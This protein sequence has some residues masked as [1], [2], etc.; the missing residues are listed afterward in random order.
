MPEKETLE[1]PEEIMLDQNKMAE[2]FK[3]FSIGGMQSATIIRLLRIL[4]ML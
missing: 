1:A 2:G 3:Y 4:L